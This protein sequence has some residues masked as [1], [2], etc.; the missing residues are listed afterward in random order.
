MAP[1]TNPIEA[2]PPQLK[3]C[4]ITQL[5][6]LHMVQQVGAAF[7]GCIVNIPRSP[8]TITVAETTALGRAA[9]ISQV[10][11]IETD[12]PTEAAHIALACIPHA[13]QL[14]TDAGLEVLEAIRNTVPDGVELWLAVGLP[15]RGEQGVDAERALDRIRQAAAAGISRIVLDTA[16]RA[17]TGGTGTVSDWEAAARIVQTAPLPVMLAGGITPENVAEAVLTVRPHGIDVSSGVEHSPGRKD[18]AKIAQLAIE[19]NRAAAQLG[20]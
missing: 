1:D 3:V 11:V 9:R 18:P 5:A 6:D 16:T 4:G 19:L 2:A 15:P 17:G 14:H 12:N 10:C 13:L 7:F 20:R 8:R